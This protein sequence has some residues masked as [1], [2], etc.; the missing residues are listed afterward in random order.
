MENIVIDH[1]VDSIKNRKV[2][3]EVYIIDI[4]RKPVAKGIVKK[5][6]KVKT[7]CKQSG[8]PRKKLVTFIDVEKED[9]TV[10]TT[11]QTYIKC[12]DANRARKVTKAIRKLNGGGQEVI[13]AMRFLQ[14]V[15]K[16]KANGESA[17]MKLLQER[18]AIIVKSIE[19]IKNEIEILGEKVFLNC[20]KYLLESLKAHI[21]QRKLIDN[22]IIESK[23][24]KRRLK[25][26][27]ERGL[28]WK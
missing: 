20:N 19:R 18:R 6:Y 1:N 27:S 5:I 17:F 3:E 15:D 9:K 2:G 25:A 21:E 16:N 4:N 11:T 13:E 7:F 22:M 8:K 24:R 26:E 28:L 23:A 10:I 14:A 12:V